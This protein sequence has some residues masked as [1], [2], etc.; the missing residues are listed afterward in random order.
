MIRTAA[1]LLSSAVLTH[2]AQ[3]FVEAESFATHG[4]PDSEL[5]E[6]IVAIFTR[7]REAAGA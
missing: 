4:K 5:L 6:P 2:A 3:V 7:L 1:A